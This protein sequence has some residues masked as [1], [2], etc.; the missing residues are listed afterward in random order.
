MPWNL[1]LAGTLGGPS[2]L[3]LSSAVSSYSM[4]LV[5]PESCVAGTIVG[6]NF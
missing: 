1:F 3:R 6:C 2:L 4:V 5:S